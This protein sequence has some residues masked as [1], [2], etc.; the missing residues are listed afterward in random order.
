MF[1]SRFERKYRPFSVSSAG[2][3]RTG[4]SCLTIS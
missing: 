4:S 3:T 1:W 2:G